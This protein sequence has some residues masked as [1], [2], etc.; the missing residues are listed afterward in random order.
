MFERAVRELKLDELL[1]VLY[2]AR[3]RGASNDLFTGRI[4]LQEVQRRGRWR[5]PSSVRR[6]EKR[7]LIQAVWSQMGPSA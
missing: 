1:P 3:H 7:G 2:T 6:C 5:Q 4:S